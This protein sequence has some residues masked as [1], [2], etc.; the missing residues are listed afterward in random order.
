VTRRKGEEEKEEEEEDND[1]DDDA[2]TGVETMRR[3]QGIDV[4]HDEQL[5]LEHSLSLL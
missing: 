1:D 4:F 2:R 5:L 3:R